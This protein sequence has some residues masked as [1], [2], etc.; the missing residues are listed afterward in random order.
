MVENNSSKIVQI[1]CVSILL[2][3]FVIQFSANS[4][5]ANGKFEKQKRNT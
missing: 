4:S 1:V 5:F 2:I 3:I